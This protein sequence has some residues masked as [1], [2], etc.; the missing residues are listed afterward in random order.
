MAAWRMACESNFRLNALIMNRGL[1]NM[2]SELWSVNAQVLN[3]KLGAREAA[4]RIQN[5]FAKWYLPQQD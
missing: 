2:E 1:P 5:G 3:G 4:A